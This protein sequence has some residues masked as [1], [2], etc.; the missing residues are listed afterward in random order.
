MLPGSTEHFVIPWLE[1]ASS[2]K[3]Q[4]DFIV[5]V[6]PEFLREGTA[7]D[8]FF[9]PPMI[10][11]GS[12]E[13]EHAAVI[14]DLYKGISG[15]VFCTN[16][17]SAEMVKYAC[18]AFHAVKV[19]FANEIGT[20]GMHIGVNPDTVAEVFCSDAKLNASAA[21]LRPGGA[22][23]GSCLPKDIRALNY[24]SKELDLDLPLLRSVL[25]S[26]EKHIERTVN[27][28]LKLKGRKVGFLG[29]SFK[30]NTD[31]LRES[32]N[33]LLVK[34]LLGEGFTVRIWD[35][36]VSLGLLIGSNRQYIVD[37]IPHVGSLLRRSMDE[38]IRSCDIVVLATTALLDD[39]IRAQLRPDQRFI[40]ITRLQK[41]V[42]EVQ[43]AC[44]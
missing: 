6:N 35:D 23:G 29:L 10:V 27:E 5:C 16:I 7:V 41:S 22:F 26:N 19:A 20:L 38:V 1:Q 42:V 3:G 40:N 44:V 12:A 13:P 36:N 30:A 37:T 8:D 2:K 39:D 17:A 31:D 18:N 9:D 25:P 32:P 15:P 4:K 28:I 14:T 24:L 21:Y 33:V 34:R 11:I 43:S